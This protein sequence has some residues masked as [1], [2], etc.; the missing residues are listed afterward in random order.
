MV[1]VAVMLEEEGRARDPGKV[2]VVWD[3]GSL[4]GEVEGRRAW[5]SG[6]DGDWPDS[7]GMRVASTGDVVCWGDF[8][9]DLD[10]GGR[11]EGRRGFGRRTGGVSCCDTSEPTRKWWE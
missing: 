4:A 2:G 11:M 5:T 3:V 1:G 7:T 10:T 8:K 6:R 9:G